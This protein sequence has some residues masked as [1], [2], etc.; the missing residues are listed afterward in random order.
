MIEEFEWQPMGAP[1]PRD[2]AAAVIGLTVATGI[3]CA[4][5]AVAFA[6]MTCVQ[7]GGR[8]LCRVGRHR[9]GAWHSYQLSDL[10]R[11]GAARTWRACERER[12]PATQDGPVC[13]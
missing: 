4:A 10:E 11:V 7:V 8:A 2:R 6:L 1:R 3:Y 9:W 12:C 5:W 13:R